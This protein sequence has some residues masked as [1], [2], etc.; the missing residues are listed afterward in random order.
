MATKTKKNK[1]GADK[2]SFCPI[3][4]DKH[5]LSSGLCTHSDCVKK[6]LWDQA[7]TWKVIRKFWTQINKLGAADDCVNFLIGELLRE[8]RDQGKK[9]TLNPWWAK[10]RLQ[11][12]L[13]TG[14]KKSNL[15]L[16]AVPSCYKTKAENIQSISMDALREKHADF[17]DAMFGQASSTKS[18]TISPQTQLEVKQFGEKI[19]NKFGEALFLHLRDEINR[20]E[21]LK[22]SPMKMIGALKLLEVCKKPIRGL[23][24]TGEWENEKQLDEVLIQLFSTYKKK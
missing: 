12:Y 4:G 23:Y 10:F 17:F 21:Y 20:P 16:Q 19:K 7:K 15:P 5:A 24:V 22:M 3:H 13:A 18:D 11:K 2:L 8:E 14:L 6:V 1:W 9:P